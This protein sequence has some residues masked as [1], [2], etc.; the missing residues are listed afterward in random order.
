MTEIIFDQYVTCILGESSKVTS[1]MHSVKYSEKE[2]LWILVQSPSTNRQNMGSK[3]QKKWKIGLGCSEK[4]T[5]FS[6]IP[7]KTYVFRPKLFFKTIAVSLQ[8]KNFQTVFGSG[9]TLVVRVVMPSVGDSGCGSPRPQ[10]KPCWDPNSEYAD[11]QPAYGEN[12]T[13]DVRCQETKTK[14]KRIFLPG[15]T[16]TVYLSSYGGD[17][18]GLE[19]RDNSFRL[20][21][22]VH[23]HCQTFQFL[24]ELLI[25]DFFS[26]G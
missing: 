18:T 25:S 12:S 1:K 8:K 6:T 21:H 19:I 17:Q 9:F 22:S 11:I 24:K 4:T 23:W 16:R 3:D 7:R 20:P 2:I 26:I 14:N 15:V 10:R 5:R 13:P